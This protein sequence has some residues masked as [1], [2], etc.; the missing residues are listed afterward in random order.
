MVVMDIC[1]YE[2]QLET[3]AFLK[4]INIGK[5]EISDGKCQTVDRFFT[6]MEKEV[7]CFSD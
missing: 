2:E 5:K 1:T 4:L 7:L 3:M 6:D